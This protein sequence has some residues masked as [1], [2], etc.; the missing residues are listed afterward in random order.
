MYTRDD[1]TALAMSICSLS[2]RSRLVTIL[3]RG[4]ADLFRHWLIPD[5][6]TG[7]LFPDDN[8]RT[9]APKCSL[10]PPPPPTPNSY[11][12]NSN[13]QCDGIRKW[14]LQEMTFFLH[15]REGRTLMD[16]ISAFIK[17]TLGNSLTPSTT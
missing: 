13:S 6:T 4:Q 11:I 2:Q 14:G 5:K 17:G 1:G 7:S 16:E 3:T 10:R 9:L 8:T 15:G 12:E